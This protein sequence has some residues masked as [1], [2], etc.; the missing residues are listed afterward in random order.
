MNIIALILSLLISLNLYSE[1]F[2]RV[3]DIDQLVLSLIDY[4]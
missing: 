1:I 4:N 2:F 3:F